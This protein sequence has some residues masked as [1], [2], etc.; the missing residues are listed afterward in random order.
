MDNFCKA[1]SSFPAVETSIGD[2]L[3]APSP[4]ELC[5]AANQIILLGAAGQ[6]T[7]CEQTLVQAK[8]RI[9]K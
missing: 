9:K 6:S 2:S 5:S 4:N 1:L 7:G 3:V 8:N